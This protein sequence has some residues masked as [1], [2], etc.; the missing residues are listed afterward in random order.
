[1]ELLSNF[2]RLRWKT[3]FFLNPDIETKKKETFGFNTQK[4]APLSPELE[5]FEKDLATIIANVKF[6]NFRSQFQ[7]D[8]AKCV[9]SIN[10]TGE[11]LVNADKTS[12]IYKVSKQKYDKLMLDN[13]TKDYKITSHTTVDEINSEACDIAS[14]LELEDRIEKYSDHKKIHNA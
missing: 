6:S 2:L 11:L 4:T 10:K 3:F 8:L 14:K 7:S 13:I 9:K 1:M 12:N 5:K